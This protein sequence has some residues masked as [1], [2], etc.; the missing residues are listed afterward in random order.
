MA[1]LRWRIFVFVT[2]D[3]FLCGARQAAILQNNVAHGKKRWG[4]LFRE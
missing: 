3:A 2:V 4:E 1:F